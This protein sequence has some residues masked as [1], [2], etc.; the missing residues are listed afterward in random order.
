MRWVHQVQGDDIT[1]FMNLRLVTDTVTTKAF[2]KEGKTKEEIEEEG[3]QKWEEANAE[4]Q[5]LQEKEKEKLKKKNK[6]VY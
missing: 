2:A 6:E 1:Q 5:E 4:R 3:K